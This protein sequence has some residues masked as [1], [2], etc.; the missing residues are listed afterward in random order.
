[1]RDRNLKH[2]VSAQATVELTSPTTSTSSGFVLSSTSSKPVITA[3]VWR[4]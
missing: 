2:G 3:A 4:A 1:M